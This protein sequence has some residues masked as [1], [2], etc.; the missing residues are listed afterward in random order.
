MEEQLIS[1]KPGRYKRMIVVLLGIL[2]Y[3]GQR[4]GN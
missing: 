3:G 1:R 4:M 2:L